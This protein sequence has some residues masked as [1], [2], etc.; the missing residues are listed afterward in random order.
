MAPTIARKNG[1]RYVLNSKRF[2]KPFILTPDQDENGEMALAAAVG[3]TAFSPVTVTQEGPEHIYAFGMSSRRFRNFGDFGMT[4]MLTD[5]GTGKQLMNR[6]VHANTIFGTPEYPAVLAQKYF[7]N[8]QRG[9]TCHLENL[10]AYAQADV[11]PA[12]YGRRIY[13]TAADS[14]PIANKVKELQEKSIGTFP[15]FLTTTED[16]E[17]TDGETNT[18]FFPAEGD[19]Y[20]EI[21]KI[22]AVA[23]DTD[24]AQP[25]MDG[26]FDFIIRDAET[27]RQLHSGN[28]TDENALGTGETPYILPESLLILPKQ[29]IELV[30]TNTTPNDHAASVYITLHGRKIYV[31]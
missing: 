7:L 3:A 6:V 11:R 14:G 5:S 2:F 4:C 22:A 25:N 9:F 24:N 21:F 10:F 28:L 20:V 30:I 17:L 19:S 18:Y 16:I 29:R 13:S 23:Y 26:S 27:R 1:K 31:S 8:E 12:F 15:Y